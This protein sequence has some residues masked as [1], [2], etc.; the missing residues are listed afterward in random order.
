M[1]S[2]TSPLV[3]IDDDALARIGTWT[4]GRF[5]PGVTREHLGR[6]VQGLDANP[7]VACEQADGAWDE[8]EDYHYFV[9]DKRLRTRV[10]FDAEGMRMATA[11]VRKTTLETVVLR[12]HALDVRVALAEERPVDAPAVAVPTQH[13]RIKQRKRY[14]AG[15]SP[16]VVDCSTV[17]SGRTRTAAEQLQGRADGVFE[18]E[19]EFAPPPDPAD[20]ASK[21]PDTTT[22]ARRLARSLVHKVAGLMMTPKVH[23]Q[24]L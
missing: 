5:V 10:S 19:C 13:V 17:W 9:D 6:L 22:G 18:V 23:F 1:K 16:F 24:A 3:T 21:Y 12:T 20:W 4:D 2:A 11:T 15:A 8:S 14:R 7:A